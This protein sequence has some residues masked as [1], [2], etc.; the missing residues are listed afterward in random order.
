[1]ELLDI[2]RY[3]EEEVLIDDKDWFYHAFSFENENIADMLIDGIKA[4]IL[5]NRKKCNGG[6]NGW[7]YVSVLKHLTERPDYRHAYSMYST[8]P[9]FIIDGIHPIKCDKNILSF[10]SQYTPLPFRDSE[11]LDEYQQFLKISANKIR[12]VQYKLYASVGYNNVEVLKEFRQLLKLLEEL[13][14]KIDIYDYSFEHAGIIKR[15][16]SSHFLELTKKL[17]S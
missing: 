6:N 4:P 1:M 10:Y 3:S 14:K 17:D 5:I 9:M 7:F 13:D 8:H 12:G 11:Y 15:V 2:V 16:N